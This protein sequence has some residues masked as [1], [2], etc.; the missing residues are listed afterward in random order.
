MLRRDGT[1]GWP[2][3]IV[4]AMLVILG[5]VVSASTDTQTAALFLSYVLV[6]GLLAVRRP[7]NLVSW[8]VIAIA[9]SFIG[10]TAQP[11]VDIKQL[12]TA[13]ASLG[14]EVWAALNTWSGSVTFFL[15]AVLAAVFPT[16]RLPKGAW[17]RPLTLVLAISLAV[18][19]ASVFSPKL[20]VPLKGS[21]DVLVPNPLGLIP[22]FPWVE[23]AV[24]AGF[25]VTIAAFGV[26]IVSL[27]VRYRGETETTRLQ[28]RWLLAAISCVLAGIVI[29]VI[30]AELWSNELNGLEW[31]PVIIAYPTVPV[32]IAV[33]IFR[34]RL[35]EID[36]IVNRTLVYGIVTAILAGVFAAVTLL[37]Q[38]LYIG[39]TGQKSDAAIV[40]TTLV[41][42]ALFA[43]VRKQVERLV[44]RYFKY[45]Q[46]LFGAYREELRRTIDVLAPA[47]AAHRLAR[48]AMAETGAVA[49]AVMGADGIVVASAGEWPAEPSITLRVNDGAA[50][51]AAVLLGPRRDGRPHRPQAVAALG[52]VAAMAAVASAAIP[53]A[54]HAET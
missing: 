26:S 41:V 17:R 30:L 24:F 52:E 5:L 21:D 47:P 10:T 44:D 11:G 29:S 42:A 27:L 28:L 3:R 54:V 33:A 25:G 14:D 18:I 4:L 7:T 19:V 51:I 16:G 50:P 22:D 2:A 15:Y 36:R 37:T 45:D 49:A 6:G 48:E 43:P 31:I 13:T 34:Y 40:L 39:L 20:I 23:Q 53:A 1:L 32:A 46:R 38:R 9:F 35:Y 12:K 8:L